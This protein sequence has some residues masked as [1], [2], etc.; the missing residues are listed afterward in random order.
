MNDTITAIRRLVDVEGVGAEITAVAGPAIGERAVVEQGGTVIAGSIPSEIHDDVIADAEGLMA[1]EQSRTLSYG[2]HRVFI[3]TIAPPPVLAV[4]GAGHASQPLAEF[5]HSLG[6]RVIVIDSREVWATRERFPVV[7]ELIVGL[8]EAFFDDHS[9]DE[10]SY[11]AVMNHS[12]KFEDPVYAKVRGVRVRYLGAMGSR[13]THKARVERL[14]AAGWTEEEIG[15]IHSPIGLD[16]G[17]ETPEEMAL[18]I[19]AEMTQVRY[20]H[21]TGLSLRGT[22]GRIHGQRQEPAVE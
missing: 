18:G 1:K 22:A 10:R 5:A 16:I 9:F 20:G 6:F 17:A 14:A 3:S 19:L 7:D 21:G 15:R 12:A 13:R 4:F 2:D 11:V 8:P